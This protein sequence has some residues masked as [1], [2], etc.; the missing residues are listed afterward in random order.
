[1][2]S[3]LGLWCSLI[4]V[5]IFLTGTLS[6]FA[7][8][9]DWLLDSERRA[10]ATGKPKIELSQTYGAA[11]EFRPDDTIVRL[12][13]SDAGYIADQVE[14]LTEAG[15]RYV[16]VDPYSGTVNGET[17]ALSFR[18]IVAELHTRLFIPGRLGIMAVTVFSLALTG[19]LVAGIILLP[20][21]W[22]S[23]TTWP[24]FGGSRRALFSDLHRLGGAWSIPFVFIICL[25]TLYYFAETLNLDAP[26]IDR[27]VNTEPRA[28]MQPDDMSERKIADALTTARGIYPELDV[29]AIL[30]PRNRVQPIRIEGYL[31]AVLVRERANTVYLHPDTLAVIRAHRGEDLS[32]HQRISEA[33]DP[34]HWGYWGGIWSRLVWFIFG[35]MLTALPVLGAVIFAK[36]MGM[37]RAKL[38]GR[39]LSGWRVYWDGMGLGKWGALGL[40]AVALALMLKTIILG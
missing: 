9:I 28:A 25:T 16:W 26:P 32:V 12:Y 22:K 33:V 34:I 5:F 27:G 15:K 40:I 21:F 7:A 23:F 30:L 37:R 10:S 39:S 19:S 8:E 11:Q 17:S 4:F 35:L 29:K 38:E 31:D 18:E 2:H 24:R 14:I 6:L 20:R 13:R 3:F 36:R 1:M